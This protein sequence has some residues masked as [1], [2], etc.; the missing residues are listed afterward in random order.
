VPKFQ[1]PK[2]SKKKQEV[3][4]KN[5]QSVPRSELSRNQLQEISKTTIGHYN[6]AAENFRDG[7]ND[8]DVSQNYNAMLGAIEGTEP[9]TILDFGCGPGRDLYYFQ[10]LGHNAIGLDGSKKFVEMARS[11]SGCKVYQQD[12]IAMTLPKN[13]FDG[14]FANASLFHVPSQ[15]LP[16]VLLGLNMTLKSR[17]I[18]FCSNPRGNNEEGMGDSR[19]SCF[20][21]YRTWRNY[22]TSARF[23]EVG[24][25]Y[26]PE[27]LPRNKQPWLATIW[28]KT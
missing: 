12:F 1:K 21:D 9:Y 18:L 22:V 23:E 16:K 26:R 20:Y 10:S 19:Y 11:Y 3:S 25:Y 6:L 13:Y 8:H 7:T 24:H 2:E 4:L 27:G 28:R 14:I 15:E 17:G 5:L